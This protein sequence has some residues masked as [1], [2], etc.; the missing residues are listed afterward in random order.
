MPRE[1]PLKPVP[2][3]KESKPD[4]KKNSD[5]AGSK[6]QT[7]VTPLKKQP[8]ARKH[9]ERPKKKPGR[10]RS[11]EEKE[12]PFPTKRGGKKT[13]NQRGLGGTG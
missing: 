10:W 7:W 8:D 12:K 4:E 3:R 9:G 5:N 11:R 13:G 1:Y 2:E 6:K